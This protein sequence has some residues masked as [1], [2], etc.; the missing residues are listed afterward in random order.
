MANLKPA[1]TFVAARTPIVDL[2]SGKATWSFIKILQD[3][4][5]KLRNGLNSQGQFIG[6]ISPTT[7]IAGRTEIGTILQ[8]I[9]DGGR[10][11]AP[12][13]D[14]SRS[15]LNK[16]TDHIGDGTGSPLAG[17]KIAYSTLVANNPLE[18]ET[19]RYN[20]LN[21]TVV[22]IAIS[23]PAAASQWLNSYDANTGEFTASQPAFGNI[24]GVATAAQVPPLSS[25]SGSV[26]PGQVPAL[27]ALSGA[28][29]AGQV[30]ALSALSGRITTGQLP[31]A[32]IS[33]TI[34]T[35]ALTLGG[36]QGSMTFVNGLLTAQVQAT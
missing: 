8:Y 27:S 12:G 26:T 13:I 4:D 28:V 22:A 14:F 34:T 21:W 23:K 19:I 30:P 16:D 24:S 31:T 18:G 10:V 36:T 15:Y 7:Q 2:T 32:G 11:L 6:D 1:S 35:A 9:D 33:V 20:G 3:W 17:G 5:T 25:L 29:T